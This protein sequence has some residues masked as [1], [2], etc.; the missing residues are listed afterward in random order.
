M[1]GLMIKKKIFSVFL[2][3]LA[4][5]T[6]MFNIE[7]V[8]SR[9]PQEEADV[10]LKTFMKIEKNKSK[11]IIKNKD[12]Q[13][14]TVLSY[15]FKNG[16]L[17]KLIAYSKDEFGNSE[18]HYYFDDGALILCRAIRNYYPLDDK[19]QQS[20]ELKTEKFFLLYKQGELIKPDQN[21]QNHQSY[22]DLG[23][24]KRHALID[25]FAQVVA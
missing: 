25:Y 21:A 18:D 24:E 9:S 11:I 1:G 17:Q 22:I 15:W 16:R 4:G 3:M 7:A 13:D 23:I 19:G 12:L 10:I 5:V 6:S 20:N 14:G 8:G 2:L